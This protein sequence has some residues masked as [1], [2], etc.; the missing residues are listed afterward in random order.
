MRSFSVSRCPFMFRSGAPF[1]SRQMR[2]LES[3]YERCSHTRFLVPS[4]QSSG[5]VATV[6]LKASPAIAIQPS[7]IEEAV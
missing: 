3:V 7:D 6:V 1:E 4:F 2:V 5:C